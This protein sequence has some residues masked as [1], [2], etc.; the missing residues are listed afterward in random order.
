M[1]ALHAHRFQSRDAALLFG[2]HSSCFFDMARYSAAKIIMRCHIG[3]PNEVTSDLAAF[4]YFNDIFSLGS[5]YLRTGN[6]HGAR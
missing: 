4:A 2:D 3:E 6:A 1:T 5:R